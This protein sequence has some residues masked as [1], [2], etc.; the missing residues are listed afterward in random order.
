MT[1]SAQL[2]GFGSPDGTI[3][4]DH[5]PGLSTLLFIGFSKLHSR[6]PQKRLNLLL[7]ASGL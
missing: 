2:I 3:S 1:I 5:K 6:C 7:G 4:D